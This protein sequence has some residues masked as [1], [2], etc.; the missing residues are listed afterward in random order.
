[1][2]RT[3]ISVD[4]PLGARCARPAPEI[5]IKA[6]LDRN[7]K[8]TYKSHVSLVADAKLA[9]AR[10]RCRSVCSALFFRCF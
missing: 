6:R 4:D 5:K 2:R 3:E 1:M 8:R 10:S 9:H 7:E